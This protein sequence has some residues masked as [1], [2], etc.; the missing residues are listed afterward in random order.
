M[1][2]LLKSSRRAADLDGEK[3]IPEAADDIRD[4]VIEVAKA[5]PQKLGP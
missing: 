5:S 3:E 1:C 2:N 4:G